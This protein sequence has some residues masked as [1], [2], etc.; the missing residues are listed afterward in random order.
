[1]RSRTKAA[2]F[3]DY[4]ANE[5]RYNWEL[6]YCELYAGG[7]Y[8]TNEGRNYEFSLGLNGLGACATQ[9]ASEYFDVTVT[10][11]GHVYELHFE[12]GENIGGLKK[13]PTRSLKTGTIQR[14]KPDRDVFTDIDV[15]IE[16]YQDTLKS[17]AIVNAGVTFKL[18]SE[19]TNEEESFCYPEGILGY[20]EELNAEKGLSEPYFFTGKG[21]GRDR[22]DKDDY[23]VLCDVALCFNNE[24]NLV[25]YYHNSSWLEYGGSPDRA[26]RNAFV[27]E[28]DRQL[29]EHNK[30]KAKRAK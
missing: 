6:I 7:K 4:N 26:V 29:K 11:D 10:R 24:V 30:Y 5:E 12:R 16:W 14:W 20:V 28:F 17:Q 19:V 2:V 25:K 27:A 21:T 13:T 3:P 1:M 18:W 9:Y 23:R 22:K 15:P 8:Y